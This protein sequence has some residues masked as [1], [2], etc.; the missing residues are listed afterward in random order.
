MTPSTTM[1]TDATIMIIFCRDG[2]T[3]AKTTTNITFG[4]HYIFCL[5][6]HH[7]HDND[8]TTIGPWP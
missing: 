2:H 5:E 3:T 7:D 6:R 4:D 1:T 8:R